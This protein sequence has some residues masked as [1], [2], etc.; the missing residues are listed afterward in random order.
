VG[1]FV[2]Q[3]LAQHVRRLGELQ[4]DGAG[5]AVAAAVAAERAGGAAFADRQAAEHLEQRGG[6]SGGKLLCDRPADLWP[7]AQLFG[8]CRHG[9]P[10]LNWHIDLSVW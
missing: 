6:A 9:H 3:G 2:P 10:V 4:A 5:L 8:E 7:Q 1:E